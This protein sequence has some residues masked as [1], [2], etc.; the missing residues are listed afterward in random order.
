MLRRQKIPILVVV[1]LVAFLLRVEGLAER[2]IWWDEGIGVWLAR[3]SV[4]DGIRWTAGDVHP[5]LYYVLL[6]GWRTLV[7][8]GEF[9]LRYLSVVF[10]LLTVAVAYRLGAL[11]G[12]PRTGMLTALFM[13]LSRFAIWW[14]QEI[15]M[16][17]L[18]ALW[19]TGALWSAVWCWKVSE[20]VA[21]NQG[22]VDAGRGS[23][24]RDAPPWTPWILYAFMTLSSFYTL[25]LTATVAVV[26]NLGFLVLWTKRR[27]KAALG[28]RWA[29]AQA[30]VIGLFL[31]WLYYALPRMHSWS[32]D[33]PFT[34]GF[35][36]KLYTTILA[37]GTPIDLQAY[38]PLT[39]TVFVGLTLG[40]VLL[41]R[42]SH[43]PSSFGGLAMLVGGLLL[44]PL[45]VILVSLPALSFYFSRP[46]VPRYL[47]PLSVCYTV[48]LAWSIDNLRWRGAANADRCCG[49]CRGLALGIAGVGLIAALAGL[50]T[51]Y[52]GRARRDD[53]V[54]VGE[55]LR[56]HRHPEDVVVLYVDRDWP[57]LAAHYGGPRHDLAYGAPLSELAVVEA[58]LYP[59]WEGASGVWLVST[60]E[61]LQADPQQA[62]PQWLEE[63]AVVTKTFVRGETSLTFYARTP[64]RAAQLA[65]VVPGFI[66][67]VMVGTPFG[68]AGASIPLPRYLTG[69]TLH[70]GLYWVPPVH[71]NAHVV[72]RGET[73]E[74]SYPAPP[75]S[76]NINLV[77]S[78]VS[79]PLSP[80]LDGGVYRIDV[81]VPGYVPVNVGEIELIRRVTGA[82][83]LSDIGLAAIETRV[84]VE[85]RSDGAI[86]L[87]GYALPTLAVAPGETI[88]L[89]LYWRT[90]KPL[91]ERY[92]VFTH[93]VGET[94]NASSG[95]FLWGQ[96]D[97]EP[98]NGQA[99]TTVWTP[100]A[101]IEDGYRIALDPQA[102]SGTYGI[103]VGLYGLIDGVR[104]SATSPTQSITDNAVLLATVTVTE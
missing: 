40:V 13:A 24:D 46:L 39:L 35:F 69:D 5:P 38:L 61:S 12:G 54:T 72:L 50:V 29:A 43:V 98:A 93:V 10:S 53:F 55:I 56:A 7:G 96:Q 57:I 101:I 75:P 16:Y 79:I 36:L 8:E 74:R 90:T 64:Q 49:L 103:V 65:T 32:S 84:N 52:P 21:P 15:R 92:K 4:Q 87:L 41:W 1:L 31:P 77:R 94:Y 81:V 34:P 45:V 30:V 85:F 73:A 18:A 14:A 19:A 88:P 26:T 63:R 33:A 44:P 9:V 22:A 99:P 86:E 78:Q 71:R 27:W 47:L 28:W 97:N 59:L 80:D 76:D 91:S 66:V 6:W 58:R 104:L 70:L 95:T 11:L 62:V 89:T 100:G 20:P 102:P 2:N 60:P 68:L 37:V 23:S 3:M 25:Y 83:R 48:L 51:Y 82:E 17:A 67:P 42:R